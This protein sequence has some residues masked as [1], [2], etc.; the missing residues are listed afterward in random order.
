[1]KDHSCKIGRWQLLKQ[2]LDNLSPDAFRQTLEHYPDAV[3]LDVRTPE[4]FA[5]GALPG[6]L[7]L[8]YLGDD[9][10]DRL[11]CLDRDKTY[12]VYCRTSRR[13]TR[14][15]VL[16]KNSGFTRVYN[17]ESGWKNGRIE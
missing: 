7:H 4:E 6:A 5:G 2:Q 8:N 14:T 1:M 16:M 3:I 15:C 9:F 10:I 13:S 11:L 12:F 17:L